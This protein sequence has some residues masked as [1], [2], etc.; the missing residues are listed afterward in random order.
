MEER[1]I[2]A[3]HNLKTN[4]L[5]NS[6]SKINPRKMSD[7]QN[8]N[9]EM[10]KNQEAS[11]DVKDSE[12]FAFCDEYRKISKAGSKLMQHQDNVLSPN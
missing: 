6:E 11:K 1:K 7:G 12:F 4:S 3:D 5:T 9:A 2:K 10:G 8:K